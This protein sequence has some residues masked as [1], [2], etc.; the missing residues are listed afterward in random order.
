M[1]YKDY[2]KILG[3]DRAASEEVIKRTYRK[4]ARQ[5]HPDVNPGDEAAES[6]FKGIN[7][8]YQVLGD[9]EKRAKYDRLGSSWNRWQKAGHDPGSYDWSQWA[10]P[11]G[12]HNRRVRIDLSDLDDL[13]GGG[14]GGFSSFFDALFGGGAPGARRADPHNRPTRGRDLEQP[15]EISLDE[16]YSGTIRT[17]DRG[18]SRMQAKIPPGAS[19]GTRVRL[20]GQGAPN[21][22]G[23]P[24]DLYLRISV[25]PHPHIQRKEDDLHVE[26]PVDLYTAVLGGEASVET[27][28][29]TVQLKIPAGTQ[30]GQVFRLRGKGMPNLRQKE[31]FGDLYAKVLLQIP[32]ELSDRE[33]KLFQELAA[34]RKR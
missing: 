8:A 14:A 5:L 34:L 19:T 11:G 10:S 21:A 16:A 22:A 25:K 18:G 2:Y 12:A 1:E 32:Q 3:V 13:L 7:E 30:S 20:A 28:D 24:G 9:P 15:V 27:M 26:T 4:L 31:R 33:K 17:L 6:R 29:G 23:V